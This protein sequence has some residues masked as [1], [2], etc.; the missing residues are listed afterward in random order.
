MSESS[1]SDRCHQQ[2]KIF[3]FARQTPIY[4]ITCEE[5][6]K[7]DFKLSK[8]FRFENGAFLKWKRRRLFSEATSCKNIKKGIADESIS[9]TSKYPSLSPPSSSLDAR[10]T[11]KDTEQ[12]TSVS[13][14][15]AL[16]SS[17]ILEARAYISPICDFARQTQGLGLH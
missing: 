14:Y 12:E 4:T 17:L 8:T 15:S 11:D 13:V 10:R 6:K 9:I 2:R 3:E 5:G 1:D 7:R 16:Q